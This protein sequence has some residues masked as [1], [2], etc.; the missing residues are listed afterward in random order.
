M[1]MYRR[2]ALPV[3][4]I[5]PR[6][7]RSP[8]VSSARAHAAVAHQT[9]RYARDRHGQEPR[10]NLFMPADSVFSRA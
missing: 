5:L 10:G 9:G 3:F 8:P 4:V 1:T 7:V 6:R 2:W